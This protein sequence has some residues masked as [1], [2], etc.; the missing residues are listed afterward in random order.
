MARMIF[1]H[2]I[3]LIDIL[4]E[5]K[6]SRYAGAMTP[7]FMKVLDVNKV[8]L[9]QTLLSC[10]RSDVVHDELRELNFKTSNEPS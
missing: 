10:P 1:N 5:Q 8:R 7:P 4:L 9:Y 3:S 2:D 6:S